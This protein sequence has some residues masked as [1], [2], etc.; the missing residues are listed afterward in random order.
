MREVL[1]LLSYFITNN[2]GKLRSRVLD[3][4]FGSD[5]MVVA[6]GWGER[7]APRE[8]RSML[9]AQTGGTWITHIA[10]SDRERPWCHGAH[11]SKS[12]HFGKNQ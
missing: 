3:S 9:V 8:L 4:Y 2:Y 11:C 7:V 10:I 5:L 12:A 1:H 6:R